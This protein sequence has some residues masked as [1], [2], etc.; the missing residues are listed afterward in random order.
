MI[1]GISSTGSV[2]LNKLQR[3]MFFVDGTNLLYR[4]KAS[5]IIVPSLEK[6]L[7]YSPIL[8]GRE[9]VRFYFYS[10]EKHISEAKLTH[11]PKFFDG[12]RT[13]EGDGILKKG[14]EIKEK[15][16]DA[17]LVADLI[18]HAALRNCDAAILVS[19]D[20]DFRYA[21]KRVEDFGCRTG[22]LSFCGEPSERLKQSADN[23]LAYSA[24]Q[25]VESNLGTRS[26]EPTQKEKKK[27]ESEQAESLSEEV[28]DE[29]AKT[30][31][32][33]A[34]WSSE[35]K[36]QFKTLKVI[37]NKRLKE[38]QLKEAEIIGLKQQLSERAPVK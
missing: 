25:I 35:K 14:G 31:Q 29:E 5:R 20:T 16:V 8:K 4:L 33:D 11:G 32:E 37:A 26:S 12:I 22:I 6:L 30:I 19:N 2:N 21:I 18:Y 17:L 1:G 23:W 3:A 34:R 24:D 38:L 13:V 27:K 10:I 7:M 28:D 9:P 36:N 15:G